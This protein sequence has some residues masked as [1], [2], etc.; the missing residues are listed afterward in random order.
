MKVY[1]CWSGS[2]SDRGMEAVF[3]TK[4]KAEKYLSLRK[5]TAEIYD[6][7]DDKPIEW[8]VDKKEI[9]VSE[10]IIICAWKDTFDKEW[11]VSIDMTYEGEL[12]SN[13]SEDGY[14]Y[15]VKVKYNDKAIMEKSAIDKVMTLYARDC[16]L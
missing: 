16:G 2:Y 12:E 7:V 8:E 10:Y 11:I 1:T 6:D 9:E 14:M 3:S 5:N 13:I 15:Y 4:D